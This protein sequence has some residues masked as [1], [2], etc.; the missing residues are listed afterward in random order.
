MACLGYV[1]A[2]E[3]LWLVLQSQRS[4][5][6]ASHSEKLRDVFMLTENTAFTKHRPF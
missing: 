1:P 4:Y 2:R 5:K 3:K 6:W